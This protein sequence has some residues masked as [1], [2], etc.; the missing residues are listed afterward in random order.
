MNKRSWLLFVFFF[1]ILTS[2]ACNISQVSRIFGEYPTNPGDLLFQDGFSDPSS[3]WDRG[4]TEEGLTDYEN[5]RYRILVNSTN[6]DF[7]SN[8]GLYFMNVQ[9]E[10]DAGKIDTGPATLCLIHVNPGTV[11]SPEIIDHRR[12]RPVLH[13][14]RS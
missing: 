7:W 3:G 14:L 2:L 6:A 4:S 10:V 8:P 11:K 5:D 9:V 1:L 13:D 12:H